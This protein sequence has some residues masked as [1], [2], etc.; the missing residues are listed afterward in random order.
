MELTQNYDIGIIERIKSERAFAEALLDEVDETSNTK[1]YPVTQELLR[2]LVIGTVGFDALSH[3]LLMTGEKLQHLL[4]ADSPPTPSQMS[5]ITK[6]LK[7][8]MGVA[9]S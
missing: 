3:S 4:E 9:A 6:A 5:A 1:E 2:V 8:A 7:L